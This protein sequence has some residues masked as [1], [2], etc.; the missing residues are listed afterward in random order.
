MENGNKIP[1]SLYFLEHSQPEVI[2]SSNDSSALAVLRDFIVEDYDDDYDDYSTQ[3]SQSTQEEISK[4]KKL[5]KSKTKSSKSYKNSFILPNACYI[6][7]PTGS[8]KTSLVHDEALLQNYDIIEINSSVVRS[9]A[10]VFNQVSEAL[11][12]KNAK[13]KVKNSKLFR[14]FGAKTERSEAET[15]PE[16]AEKQSKEAKQTQLNTLILIDDAH[17][18]TEESFWESGIQ[19]ICK[20]TKIPIVLTSNH[21]VPSEFSDF[22]IFQTLVENGWMFCLEFDGKSFDARRRDCFDAFWGSVE[23]QGRTSSSSSRASSPS[24]RKSSFRSHLRSLN[25]KIIKIKIKSHQNPTFGA[26]VSISDADVGRL[27]QY[28]KDKL[29]SQ[30]NTGSSTSPSSGS[31]NFISSSPAFLKKMEISKNRDLTNL[32]DKIFNFQ[33]YEQQFLNFGSKFC[34]DDDFGDQNST[35][36]LENYQKFYLKCEDSIVLS[37]NFK[38]F[39]FKFLPVFKNLVKVCL[40]EEKANPY[41]QKEALGLGRDFS[42]KSI[43]CLFFN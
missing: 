23:E 41:S 36:L 16:G 42:Q 4:Q 17:L 38:N 32:S 13:N 39:A 43:F 18:L 40:E 14:M 22:D 11:K 2:R 26:S 1:D 20:E 6:S 12:S 31:N 28:Q 21:S 27:S 30:K 15:E 33:C 10:S 3:E 19:R 24:N 37:L 9:G 5:K 35:K 29:D 25:T 7:G 8:G 34:F